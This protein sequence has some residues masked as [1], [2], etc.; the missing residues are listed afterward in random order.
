M[1][2]GQ[3]GLDGA[4]TLPQPVHGRVDLVGADA[5]EIEVGHQGGVAPPLGRGQLRTGVH[6]AGEYQRVGD[7]ALFARRT[8][9]LG[10]TQRLGHDT[11]RAEVSVR[12]RTGQLQPRSRHHERLA[13]QS[14]PQRLEGG[15]GQGRDVA[16]RL[17]TDL[18]PVAKAAPQQV[19][20]RLAVLPVLR[21]ILA[22]DS[23]Y[24]DRTILPRHAVIL[25]HSPYDVTT[26]L[27]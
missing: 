7:V 21:L 19:R 9:Q 17:V 26:Y 12:Q 16:E 10:Q 4:L 24:V 23:G 15:G 14:G 22:H 25:P 6:D 20:D 13:G 5:L 8:Q 1:T 2:R 27:G 18:A 11:D 3:F